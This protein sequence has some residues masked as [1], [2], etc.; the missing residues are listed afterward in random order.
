M[1]DILI[2]ITSTIIGYLLGSI[3]FA[4][5]VTRF[6]SPGIDLKTTLV[7]I[8]GSDEKVQMAGVSATSVRFRLGPKYGLLTS[9]L[10]MLKVAVPVAIFHFIFP[11]S[12]ADYLA[13]TGGIIGHNWPVYY[14]FNGGY[15]HSAIYGALFV[16]DWRAVL[17]NFFGT[18]IL[19]P[20][21]KQV[22]IASFGGVL[23]LIPWFYFFHPEPFALLYA[24]VCS[25]AYFIRI[26]PDFKTMRE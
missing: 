9:F 17:V 12:P 15:G 25:V 7:P 11:S 4:R 10:D 19:Y 20:I 14:K 1:N 22:H 23:L 8:I 18:S 5:I 24:G 2:G 3:S 16:L 6:V 13:A 21:F 26:L